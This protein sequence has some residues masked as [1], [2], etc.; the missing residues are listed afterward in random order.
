MKKPLLIA[1]AIL[2]SNFAFATV[3]IDET[4]NYSVANLANR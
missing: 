2:F 1:F 3:Y 4:F